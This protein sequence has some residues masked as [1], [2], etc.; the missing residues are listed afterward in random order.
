MNESASIIALCDAPQP[1]AQETS[2]DRTS[3]KPE[4]K[5]SLSLPSLSKFNILARSRSPS[6]EPVLAPLPAPP[7]PRRLVILVVGLKPHRKAWTLSARPGESVISYVLL[8]GCPAIVV[9][10]KL[11]A[12]LL[13]WDTLTLEKLWNVE[14]PPSPSPDGASVTETRSASGRFEGVVDVIFE[15][16][17]FCV[18]WERF[19]VPGVASVGGVADVSKEKEESG[20]RDLG[21]KG[22]LKDAIALLVAAAIQ[23]KTSEEVKKELDADRS[24]IAMW[25]IP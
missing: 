22:A 25:R 5:T 2:G 23:S 10:A 1:A 17:D 24:G 21:T 15:Y 16:L 6:P 18:D 20:T 11:E 14:L 12:P 19:V 4:H 7:V 9:P 13:A 3:E 8:N